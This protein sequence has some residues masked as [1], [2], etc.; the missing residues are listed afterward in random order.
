MSILADIRATF[1]RRDNALNQLLVINILVF[2][3]L[4]LLRAVV[5]LSSGS[6]G[7]HLLALEW[8]AVPSYLP[9]LLLRPWTLLTYA[10]TQ[11]E[12]G[13]ILFNMLTLYWFGAL[14]SEY[15][16]AR[17]LISLYV[18]GAL[19][20]AGLFLLCFNLLPTLRLQLGTTLHGA[21]ASVMAILVAAATLLPADYSMHLLFIG[22]VRIKYIAAGLIVISIVGI[23]GSN[24]GGQISH[25]G[26]A[27]MGYFYIRMLNRGRDLGRPIIVAGEWIGALLHG[28][29]RLRVSHRSPQQA[30]A[31]AKRG[32]IAQP[33]EEEINRILEK[34][35]R[36]GYESLSKDE[37]QKLFKA[38]QQ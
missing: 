11:Y 29:P 13:H 4:N 23:S 9:E 30:A 8:L 16:G 15:L 26:G 25:L 6:R 1:S 28:R 12:F 32:G 19:A 17:R 31:G 27:L 5:F 7:G 37:K 38:S 34:I 22:P 18:L 3:A 10:F 36:S 2:V 21:S 35:S 20:G 33:A 14:I 24:T